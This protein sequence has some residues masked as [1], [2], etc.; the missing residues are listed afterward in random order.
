MISQ[1]VKPEFE[2]LFATGEEEEK[3]MAILQKISFL[4]SK[5]PTSNIS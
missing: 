5:D 3:P 4:T 1:K 2:K